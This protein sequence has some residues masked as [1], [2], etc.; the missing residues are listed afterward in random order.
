[1]IVDGTGVLR[2]Y[3]PGG[4]AA[5]SFVVGEAGFVGMGVTDPLLRWAA[6]SP[7]V[8]KSRSYAANV[9][10][11]EF[12]PP[13]SLGVSEVFLFG[14]L[15]GDRA[16]IAYQDPNG[17]MSGQFTL[18]TSSGE[19]VPV[20]TAAHT[21]DARRLA[22]FGSNGI[23]WTTTGR[24]SVGGGQ[25]A[26]K[27]PGQLIA[28]SENAAL[29][30]DAGGTTLYDG[31][32][33]SGDEVVSW[34]DASAR[35]VA[36]SQGVIVVAFEGDGSTDARL[37]QIG[38][39]ATGAPIVTTLPFVPTALLLFGSQLFVGDEDGVVYPFEPLGDGRWKQVPS[40][41]SA[42]SEFST[43]GGA[44]VDLHY[45]LVDSE[46]AFDVAFVHAVVLAN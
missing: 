17:A 3:S 46:E 9:P 7:S 23:L 26:A 20:A 21:G 45:G 14:M 11:P 35:A 37:E 16:M 34:N 19:W 18:G 12:S 44:V 43:G 28:A 41:T 2:P 1:M 13:A 40:P 38:G 8:V 42:T 22:R 30:E 5:P 10:D 24:T 15:V 25:F 36:S 6:G 4:V 32:Y 27:P 39:A 33:G 31:A 29:F